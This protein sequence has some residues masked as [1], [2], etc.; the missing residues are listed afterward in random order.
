MKKY[1]LFLLALLVVNMSHAMDDGANP[2][3]IIKRKLDEPDKQNVKTYK[4]NDGGKKTRASGSVFQVVS[5]Y[6]MATVPSRYLST[7]IRANSVS[8]DAAAVE[9]LDELLRNHK[10]NNNLKQVELDRVL[11]TEP[12]LKRLI[13]VISKCNSA[14]FVELIACNVDF[15]KLLD[16]DPKRLRIKHDCC[17]QKQLFGNALAYNH[18][19]EDLCLE[20]TGF[21]DNDITWLA[22]GLR[23]NKKLLTL[24]IGLNPFGKI[25]LKALSDMLNDNMTLCYLNLSPACDKLSTAVVENKLRRNRVYPQLSTVACCLKQHDEVPLELRQMIYMLI[26]EISPIK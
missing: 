11:I 5:R 15:V 13:E 25:G 16:Y 18:T 17:G 8:I 12:F 24:D 14:L 6:D 22:D 2:S 9:L 20:H 10:N 26:I 3:S 7:S 23:E 4:T 19:L 21:D 1:F